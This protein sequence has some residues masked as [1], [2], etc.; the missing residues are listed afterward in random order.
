M[1]PGLAPPQSRRSLAEALPQGTR[2][3]L[4]SEAG[5]GLVGNY[6]G[7]WPCTNWKHS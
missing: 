4:A 2:R 1:A 3:I 7:A 6:R 5:D